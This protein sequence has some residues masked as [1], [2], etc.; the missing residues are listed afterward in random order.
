MACSL[1]N[2]A[3]SNVCP[4]ASRSI[5]IPTGQVKIHAL[6]S[7]N[8]NLGRHRSNS[9]ACSI[10]TVAIALRHRSNNVSR[11]APLLEPESCSRWAGDQH[12]SGTHKNWGRESRSFGV[13]GTMSRSQ[14][15]SDGMRSAE[16]RGVTDW[17]PE[18]DNP[19]GRTG[20]PE[21][22]DSPS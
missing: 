17:D 6:H 9:G 16:G 1:G 2:K 3:C 19:L 8:P 7:R 12:D 10:S 4:T 18:A 13:E 21:G 5:R 11:P 15:R 20:S 14:G 22:L